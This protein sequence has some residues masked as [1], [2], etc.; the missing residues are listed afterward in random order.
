MAA[1]ILPVAPIVF[2]GA[3]LL[4]AGCGV[5]SSIEPGG[6][7]GDPGGTGGESTGG[8][9]GGAGDGMGGSGAGGTPCTP[10]TSGVMVDG[11]SR[12]QYGIN[13]AW[14][15]FA[16]DFG[17]T[18]RGVAAT[19]AQRLTAM[20][21][22]KAHGVDAVRWWVFP[23]FTGGG[24]TFDSAGSPTGLGGS[25]LADITAALD[26]AAQ[27]DIHI[28]FTLFSFDNF[29]TATM[30]PHN[31]APIIS[32]PTMLSALINNVVIPFANQVKTDPNKDRVSS[33]DVINEPEWAIAATPTDGS[34]AAFTPQTTVTTVTYPVMKAFVQAVAD[35]L[36]G[37]SDKPVTVG[38][39]AIKWAKAWAGIGDFYTFHMYDWVNMSYP[40]TKSLASYGVTDKPVVLGEFPIQGLTGVSYATLVSTIYQLGYAGAMAWAYNDNKNFPWSPN[41]LSVQAFATA[42]PCMFA[43]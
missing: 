14:A 10:P 9:T 16:S 34:D 20:M 28:Q 22:M 17:N 31:L 4:A 37:A 18:T 13:Y 6:Q 15:S 27:A 1:V 21:D 29:K 7:G 11:V 32:S 5:S 36:H 3:C 8:G 12:F 35:A 24:V 33:W 23:N 43:P 39:A 26:D 2:A 38:G 41:N 40:Y 25:T 42:H 30:P 19:K